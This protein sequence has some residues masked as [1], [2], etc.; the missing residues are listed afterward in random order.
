MERIPH[1]RSE[2]EQLVQLGALITENI[3]IITEE[4]DKERNTDLA[5][6]DV[7]RDSPKIL[8]SRRLHQAQRTILAASGSLTELIAEPYNRLQE[9]ASEI[10]EARA[11]AVAVERRIAD[12]L[13]EAGEKGLDTG[14]LSKK[15]G[16]EA[17]KLCQ[18]DSHPFTAITYTSQHVS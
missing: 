17:A 18:F 7:I 2:Q 6:S 8:P 3:K 14:T 5:P 1:T 15:T 11:L 9:F 4:W 16:V 10:W 13:D 12:M